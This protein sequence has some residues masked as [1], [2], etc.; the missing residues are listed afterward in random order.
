MPALSVRTVSLVDAVSES[1][2]RAIIN[3]DYEPG[4][5]ITELRVSEDFGVARSTA[6]AAVERLVTA[7]FLERE[8]HRSARVPS[9]APE[10]VIDLYET[11]RIIESA[12]ASRIAL[13]QVQPDA[14]QAI[15]SAEAD[16]VRA[17]TAGDRD[18]VATADVAFHTALVESTGIQTL[19][20]I[21]AMIMGRAHIAMVQVQ[22]KNPDGAHRSHTEH[23]AILDAIHAGD[24]EAAEAA[25]AA[26]LSRA[27]AD[28]VRRV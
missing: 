17:A 16:L 3:A 20:D 15:E 1:L 21:Y 27:Q 11:R 8:A 18:A 10:D 25:I 13:K 4:S 23:M 12:A 24:P 5:A 9:M 22:R 26:H 6:K 2:R 28:Y 7:G 19:T 14:L